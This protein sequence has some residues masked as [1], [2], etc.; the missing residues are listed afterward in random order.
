MKKRTRDEWIQLLNE[1]AIP[2]APINAMDEVFED[3]Q[4]LHRNMLVEVNHP[5]A[6]KLKLVGVP[7]KYSEAEATVRMPPPV[8]GEHT[9]EILSGVLGYDD[10][11]IEEL[12]TA[13]VI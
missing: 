2:C 11:R 13:G 1:D 10:T 8:L 6:G 12:K 3:P 7:V 5:T 9:R 4:V